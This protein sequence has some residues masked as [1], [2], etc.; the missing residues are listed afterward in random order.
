M[1][2]KTDLLVKRHEAVYG[3]EAFEIDVYTTVG[4]DDRIYR[5]FVWWKDGECVRAYPLR[6]D[7]PLDSQRVSFHKGKRIVKERHTRTAEEFHSACLDAGWV[8]VG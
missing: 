7:E 6:K 4:D 2:L 8:A 5:G 1:S 3:G